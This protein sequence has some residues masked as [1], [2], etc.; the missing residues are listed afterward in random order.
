MVVVDGISACLNSVR[1]TS[2]FSKRNLHVSECNP[3]PV[4]HR[5][6][7]AAGTV[8]FDHASGCAPTPEHRPKCCDSRGRALRRS[9]HRP[10]LVIAPASV[11]SMPAKSAS[12]VG[13]SFIADEMFPVSS[14]DVD[15]LLP[16]WEWIAQCGTELCPK[17]SIWPGYSRPRSVWC[18]A[19]PERF[20]WNRVSSQAA[21][22]TA[23]SQDLMTRT[24]LHGVAALIVIPKAF[25]F[26]F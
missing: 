26:A 15:A 18:A 4:S 5:G 20:T 12:C 16:P 22:L 23:L 9:S 21:C 25:N 17:S 7:L 13:S 10:Y 1:C 11:R 6:A 19:L 3:C 2:T 14:P 8:T 24:K